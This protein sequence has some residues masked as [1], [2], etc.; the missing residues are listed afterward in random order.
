MLVLSR[1]SGESV[2]IGNEIRVSVVSVSGG[3]VRLA[4]EAPAE[5]PIHRDEV[6]ERIAQENRLAAQAPGDVDGALRAMEE[7]T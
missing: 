1:K 3:Q 6:L 2:C 4:I 5:V 7:G